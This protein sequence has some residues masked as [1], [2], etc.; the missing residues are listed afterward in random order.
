MAITVAGDI[1]ES[2]G[3]ATTGISNWYASICQL[4]DTSSGSRVRRD[5]TT[6]TS[7][8]EYALRP[9]LPRPISIS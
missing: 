6:A 1:A 7:S 8:R 9:R 2:I 5:G 3:A 4:T